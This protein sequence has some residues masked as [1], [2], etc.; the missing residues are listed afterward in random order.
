MDFLKIIFDWKIVLL[1]IV[2]I[3]LLPAIFYFASLNK[4]AVRVKKI[5]VT[6][7][8]T[9]VASEKEQK[10]K[11]ETSGQVKGETAYRGDSSVQ[12]KEE[13]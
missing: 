3:I 13:R 4:S 5:K 1:L 2:V 6:S 12:S 8:K 10:Q 9:E 7:R 11:S